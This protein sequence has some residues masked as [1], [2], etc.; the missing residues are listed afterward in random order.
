MSCN[1][2]FLYFETKHNT[3]LSVTSFV[4]CNERG[5]NLKV[6]FLCHLIP[7]FRIAVLR[8]HQHIHLQL[9]KRMP[10]QLNELSKVSLSIIHYLSSPE[11]C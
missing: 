11:K 2:S 4:I 1:L 10:R 3:C 5:C 9:M 8:D 6:T 7:N